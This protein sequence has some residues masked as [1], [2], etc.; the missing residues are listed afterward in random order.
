MTREE[1]IARITE[2]MEKRLGR[3]GIHRLYI[4]AMTFFQMGL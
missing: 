3:N 1:E 2:I 4:A